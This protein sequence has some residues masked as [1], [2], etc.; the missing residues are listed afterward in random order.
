MLVLSGC[1]K[2]GEGEKAAL[3]FR[4]AQSVIAALERFRAVHKRYLAT[5]QELVPVHLHRDALRPP[6]Q[7]AFPGQ[8]SPLHYRRRG[9]E[10]SLSFRYQGPGMNM[11][12]Y[13]S[14]NKK[15]MSRGYY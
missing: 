15:W 10:Y 1:E 12:E 4:R 11:C 14:S 3:G 13:S 9:K 7:D 6:L 5:L 8:S 2:P